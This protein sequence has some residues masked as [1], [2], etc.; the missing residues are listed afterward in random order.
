[1]WNR[2]FYYR[3]SNMSKAVDSYKRAILEELVRRNKA[4]KK[5]KRLSLRA[6]D[7]ILQNKAIDDPARF[8]AYNCPR[9]SG[10]TEG[11]A[12][13]LIETAQKYKK[14]KCLYLALTLGSAVEIIWDTLKDIDERCSIGAKFN[15]TKHEMRFPNGSKIKLAGADSSSKEMKKLLGQKY[16]M[17]AIDEAG[18]FTINMVKLVYQMI[19]PA[20]SDL[21]GK[22]VLLGTCE[23]IPNTF[24]ELV[25]TGKE[26][27][28]SVHKWTAYDNPFMK[29]Q[30]T[31]EVADILEKKP[32][33]IETSWYKTHYLN[34]WC[35]DDNL[36]I[37]PINAE[38]NYIDKL[39]SGKWNFVLGVDLGHDDAT[40]FS[41]IAYS[42]AS[43]ICY[44]VDTTKDT[45]MDFT[46]TANAIKAIQGK[47]PIT[48]IIIDGANKQGVEEMR[49]R[50]H[51]P[52][53]AAEKTAKADYLRMLKDDAILGTIQLV[54][55]KCG[56]L[57]TEW[58]S[59]IWK[60]D[61]KKDEDPRCQ[62]HLSDA[63]LY[64]WRECRHYTFKPPTR[65]PKPGEPGY[66][67]E[68]EKQQLAR[69]RKRR[70]QEEGYDYHYQEAA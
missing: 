67:D 40:S 16:R 28:W 11:A 34:E 6:P 25:T 7:F 44:V 1:M 8:K 49:R 19:R 56:P 50:H 59:L 55:N 52:L 41:V 15:E 17:V 27:G 46:D 3:A 63:T 12:I 62:N 36:L 60:N 21:R 5:V 33:A 26:P 57:V 14:G 47:Y 64:A 48:K 68:M 70:E 31:E 2:P 53:Y 13:E 42:T 54:A 4:K 18:S 61:L 38:R 22:L 65:K 30:W 10:K 23:N 51:L 39:P 35:T 9:R 58:S 43:P 66:E 45:Q 29:E 37:I 20:L 32:N 69:L 24:F